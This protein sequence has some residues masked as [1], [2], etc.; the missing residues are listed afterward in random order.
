MHEETADNSVLPAPGSA[1][2]RRRRN[3]R[4][5]KDRVAKYGIGFGGISVILAIVLIF[6]YLLYVV[7]PLF[8]GA[9]IETD[10]QYQSNQTQSRY[11]S[12]NEY[13]DV[14]LSVNADGTA[15]FFK[16]NSGETMLNVEL[17]L[18]SDAISSVAAGSA[19]TGVYGYGLNDGSAFVFKR[20]YKI[21][22]PT[23]TQR[24]IVPSIEYPLGEKRIEV[25][26]QG[27]A[28]DM[29]SVQS[30]DNITS[31]AAVTADKRVVLKKIRKEENF[32][33]PTQFTLKEA[34]AQIDLN[35]SAAIT[36][37]RLDI[38]Q[39]ELYL[40]DDKGFIYFYDV[41]DAA[42]PRLVQKVKAVPTGVSVTSFE[43]LT[44]GI[45][46]L[47]GRSDGQVDQWFPVRDQDNNYY[48][49]NVRS[50]NEQSDAIVAIIP[51]EARKGFLTLD[52]S[53]NLGI[54]HTTAHRTL[55][56]EPY[57]STADASLALSP[58]ANGLIS[59]NADGQIKKLHID[60]EHPDISW[61]ALWE[62][63]WYESRQQ[64]EHIWQSSSASNDFEPKFSL[65][66]LTFGTIKAAFYAMLVA[67]PLAIMGA[68]YTAYF[69]SP[70]MRSIV[71]P[72]IEIMEALPTVILGFLAGLWLA[73][74]VEDNL[75]GVFTI[76][77][78]LPLMVILTAWAWTKLPRK[79]R[80]SIPDGWEAAILIPTVIVVGIISMSLS[81]TLELWLFDGNMPQF[82]NDVGID[83]DQRNS[84]VVGLVMGFAVIPT[85]FSITED[86]IFGVPKHL[87]VGSL[88]LGATPWQ[89][90]TRVVLLTASPGIFS[91]V[92]IGL[93]RAVG[94]TMIVLMATGN[95]PIM[96]FNIFEGFRA[97]SAN[98]AVE[99]PESEVGSSHY[100][101]LFLAALVLFLATFVLN[102]AAEVVRQRLRRKYSTL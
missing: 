87:T 53:G 44:G 101:V 34:S 7:L 16:A 97:L 67:I 95:T 100:R 75:P 8:S 4:E 22:Y 80:E 86:A 23:G 84:L 57:L 77:I 28:L 102:T 1:I 78:T 56:V 48:L 64:P 26:P 73:P 11:L 93:G 21:T 66:P 46:V 9:S 99:M 38:D 60:N 12:M 69:M 19:V 65:T 76:L 82:L 83:F 33:D 2:A 96:D 31:F 5:V 10:T 6:F 3:W 41:Q 92:M 43:F 51:E 18:D 98:I 32:I 91:A 58:R 89:T 20:D 94:E 15:H 50:F 52:R 40:V 39:R 27:Q 62:K 74:L 45:S 14:A 24:V 72:S 47:V 54:Y 25:D 49:H 88:A 37:L 30:H 55:L 81:A 71:K 17:P 63:V 90:M 35:G 79:F 68:I 42:T 85:I 61:H 70:K 29:L 59:I 36:H 13:N